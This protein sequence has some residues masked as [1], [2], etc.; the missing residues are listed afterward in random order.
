VARGW[1]EGEAQSLEYV[2]VTLGTRLPNFSEYL[3]A[4]LKEMLRSTGHASCQEV[5]GTKMSTS[6]LRR[7]QTQPESTSQNHP[8]RCGVTSG[9]VFGCYICEV[10]AT[11]N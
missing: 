3:I 8:L 9:D 10:N 4:S 1:G 6:F 11:D 2:C 5:Q 7:S